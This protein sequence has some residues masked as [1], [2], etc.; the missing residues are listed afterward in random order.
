M[1]SAT[2]KCRH[3]VQLAYDALL[4]PMDDDFE[5][6]EL[7]G[8]GSGSGYDPHYG[9]LPCYVPLIDDDG[10]DPFALDGTTAERY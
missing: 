9:E 1:A 8:E 2:W 10:L 5:I 6:D 4:A 7:G 3:E